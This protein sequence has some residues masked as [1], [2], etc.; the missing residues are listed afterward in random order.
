MVDFI[1]SLVVVVFAYVCGSIPFGYIIGRLNGVDVRTAGS[2]NIGATN[3]TRCVG[4]RAGKICFALDFLKGLVPVLA[5]ELI[6][7][8][9]D[10][11]VGQGHPAVLVVMFAAILGHIF[12]VFLN[13]RGGKGVST[14]AGAIMALAPIPLITA[15]VV[16]VVVFLVSRYVSLASICAAV[17]VPVLEWVFV[18]TRDESK[19]VALVLTLIATLAV[20]RHRT[21]I[22]RLLNG[23]E[24]RFGR[25]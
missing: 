7:G 11:V 25:K 12:P 5:A 6:L 15:L 1:E 3:V 24:N 4:R 22:S 23:T 21:N 8:K 14:A 18:L 17:T 2:K 10:L 13:F 19:S 16:W 20:F 9:G